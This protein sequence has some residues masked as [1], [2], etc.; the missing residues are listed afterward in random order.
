MARVMGPGRPPG[1]L[2][3]LTHD[4]VYQPVCSTGAAP[5]TWEVD[6]FVI[7]SPKIKLRIAI[8]HQG[9]IPHVLK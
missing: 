7:C 3:V 9:I 6:G 5:S 4:C 8:D 1:E 2:R